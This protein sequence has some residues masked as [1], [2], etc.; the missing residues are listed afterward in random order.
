MIVKDR[1]KLSVPVRH[2]RDS[3]L[4]VAES[5]LNTLNEVEG[6]GLSANQIGVQNS[7]TCVVTVQQDIILINPKIVSRSGNTN[8]TEG[9]LSFPGTQVQTERSVWVE[10][11]ADSWFV[12]SV[13]EWNE[14][15]GRLEFGPDFW[16]SHQESS[17]AAKKSNEDYIES[18]AVQHE[19]DHL[20]GKTIFDRR[21]EESPFEKSELD[22]LGRNDKVYVQNSDGEKFN[23]KWKYASKKTGDGG[24]WKLLET[25]KQ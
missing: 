19:I 13:G 9:C 20:N 17:E 6:Y 23:V 5:L 7:R 14:I 22:S 11:E 25:S 2:E 10:V 24:P 18:I 4:E 12:E 8:P 21:K 15:G 1:E 3:H 16:K